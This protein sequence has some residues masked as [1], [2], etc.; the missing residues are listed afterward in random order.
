MTALTNRD[1]SGWVWPV[2]IIEEFGK[3]RRPVVTDG[4]YP[5][6]TVTHRKH[7][8]VDVFFRRV[9]EDPPWLGHDTPSNGSKKFY[10]P[11][12]IPALAC[13]PGVVHKVSYS[14]KYGWNVTL[15]HGFMAT[16][17]QHLQNEPKVS[18]GHVV[19]P[20]LHLGELGFPP[21]GALRHLHWETWAGGRDKAFD[22][23]IVLRK[24]KMV[25]L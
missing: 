23:Q 12:G 15:D 16:F 2:P 25:G 18:K 17:Y 10:T 6:A 9:P 13:G 8:G 11:P 7:L 22:P 5:S 1:W 4:F 24:W 21:K 14:V 19:T 20:Q 3:R